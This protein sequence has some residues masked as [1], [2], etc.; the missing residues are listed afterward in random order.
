MIGIFEVY[1]TSR[2]AMV[3]QLKDVLARF[4]LC[5]KVIMYVKNEGAI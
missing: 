3:A 1:E 5:D 2:V 4:D